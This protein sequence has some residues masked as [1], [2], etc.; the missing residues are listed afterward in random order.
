M[1]RIVAAT[2]LALALTVT[3]AAAWLAARE[4][5]RGGLAATLV[6]TGAFDGRALV[7]R[8]LP[9]LD[10]AFVD[11]DPSLPRR[12]FQVRWDGYWVVDRDRLVDFAA[13]A[14]DRVTVWL[15]DRVVIDRHEAAGVEFAAR[16]VAVPA[17]A[18]RLAVE[19]EQFGGG[20]ALAIAVA[21]DG[22]TS[23]PFDPAELFADEPYTRLMPSLRPDTT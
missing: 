6:Q 1:T 5:A 3:S 16:Q 23:R 4:T 19:Y 21:I 10:L 12:H 11:R 20:Y 15:D 8:V 2:T 9:E 22:G 7:R 17:G 13:G 14:D 18:H